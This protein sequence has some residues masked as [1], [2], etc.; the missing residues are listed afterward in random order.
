MWFFSVICWL[1][2]VNIR[3]IH[4]RILTCRHFMCADCSILWQRS[5]VY[6]FR[7]IYRESV[8][9]LWSNWILHKATFFVS[10]INK[11]KIVFLSKMLFIRIIIDE[12]N[13]NG[14]LDIEHLDR[15]WSF[16]SDL[17]EN[18][19]HLL[20]WNANVNRWIKNCNQNDKA[21]PLAIFTCFAMWMIHVS[22]FIKPLYA[23]A[24]LHC[25]AKLL[26]LWLL[27]FKKKTEYN[28]IYRFSL[29][30]KNLLTVLHARTI[31]RPAKLCHMEFFVFFFD[32]KYRNTFKFLHKFSFCTNG[33]LS[34]WSKWENRTNNFCY[35]Y[36]DACQYII[37]RNG[38]NSHQN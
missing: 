24:H 15:T 16:Q 31:L 8:K 6:A 3:Q 17:V 34:D 1:C 27:A 37:I 22:V 13:Q 32:E 4:L 7:V 25:L 11:E 36:C 20:K 26:Q 12:L 5:N 35:H 18:K 28:V 14:F 38:K 30:K 33:S 10:I 19:I 2:S 23:C 29:D 9:H 21:R